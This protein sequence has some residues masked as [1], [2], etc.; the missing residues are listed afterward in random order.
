[1]DY[2][3]VSSAQQRLEHGAH[4]AT[5][6][7]FKDPSYQASAKLSQFVQQESGLPSGTVT[8]TASYGADANGDDQ[9]IVAAQYDYPLLL[10]GL[11]NL[12]LGRLSDGK[13]H[14]SV[15]AAGLATTDPPTMQIE[16]VNGHSGHIEIIVTPPSD[17]TTPPGITLT[18]NLRNSVGQ[19]WGPLCPP[20]LDVN[21]SD[22]D[23]G[24]FKP[25]NHCSTVYTATVTQPD[26]IASAPVTGTVGTLAEGS[27]CQ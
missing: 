16:Y 8:A 27:G 24:T 26:R 20:T 11:Q 21:H 25:D 18:C 9:V 4:L 14:I 2:A 13:L 1:V 15:Q 10:P 3:R 23:A 12:R 7:L 17:V 6:M 22:G 19:I 5:L